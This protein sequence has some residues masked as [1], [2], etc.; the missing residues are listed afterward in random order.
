MEIIIL[1][2]KAKQDSNHM[3]VIAFTNAFQ[4]I[5]S[6]G[7]YLLISY[8]Q[9]SFVIPWC[10]NTAQMLYAAAADTST[11]AFS[12]KWNLIKTN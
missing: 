10:L 8:L 3:A 6:I 4:T 5:Q 11:S 2:M 9:L 7:F 1:L 12:F